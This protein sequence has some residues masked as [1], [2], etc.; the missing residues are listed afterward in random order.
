MIN[1]AALWSCNST[2]MCRAAAKCHTCARLWEHSF[3]VGLPRRK[4]Q[5][6]GDAQHVGRRWVHANTEVRHLR[7]RQHVQPYRRH[8][9]WGGPG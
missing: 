1:N 5:Q 9:L 4:R 6:F 3:G 8:H 7:R 2:H